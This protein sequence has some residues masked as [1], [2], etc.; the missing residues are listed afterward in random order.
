MVFTFD[1]DVE[2]INFDYSGIGGG[3]FTAEA[4][5][6]GMGV[7]DSFF[8]PSTSCVSSCFDGNV[9]LTGASAIRSFT[10]IDEPGGGISSAVDN[11]VITAA[12]VPE[13]ST[14]LLLGAGFIGL[15][16]YGRRRRKQAA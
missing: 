11:I 14:A 3:V 15:L 12:R 13:P 4:L 1:F 8:D 10:F 5:D 16:G 9:T 2:S 7:V 6:A